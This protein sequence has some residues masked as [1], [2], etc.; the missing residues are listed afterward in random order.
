MK[1][2]RYW[3]WAALAICNAVI[4][5]GVCVTQLR[6]DMGYGY[7]MPGACLSPPTTFNNSK[8]NITQNSPWCN[9]IGSACAAWPGTCPG[10]VP[11]GFGQ[12][13][14]ISQYSTCEG[15]HSGFQCVQCNVVCGWGLMY[16]ANATV[17]CWVSVCYYHVWNNDSCI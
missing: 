7:Q 4:A 11:H 10:G 5:L 15:G 14:F 6:A 9:Q 3:I 2:R 17:N 12:N 1:S 13:S 16:Q 8:C